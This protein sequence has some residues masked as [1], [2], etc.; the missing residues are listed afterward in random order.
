MGVG[1][2]AAF[3]SLFS[4]SQRNWRQY[5]LRIMGFV[6]LQRCSE[7]AGSGQAALGKVESAILQEHLGK[8]I[9]GAITSGDAADQRGKVNE[10]IQLLERSR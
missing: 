5:S 10:L 9:E 3:D 4:H 1:T 7:L 6:N 8:C 2:L